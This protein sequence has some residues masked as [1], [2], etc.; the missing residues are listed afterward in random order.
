MEFCY[1]SYQF[2]SDK[3]RSTSKVQTRL[4]MGSLGRRLREDPVDG[5][6]LNNT[7]DIVINELNKILSHNPKVELQL[8]VSIV[9]ETGMTNF[10]NN[11]NN[12]CF[13]SH[14]ET[15][16]EET[17]FIY[18]E[19][20]LWNI[21]LRN[22]IIIKDNDIVID[23][24]ANIGLFSIFCGLLIPSIITIAIEPITISYEKLQNNLNYYNLN[25]L[26]L[27][28]SIGMTEYQNRPE[29]VII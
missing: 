27:K 3:L 22:G 25:S 16:P 18:K 11:C 24:G 7:I 10:D 4:K 12:Y 2:L 1:K 9:T 26:A 19:I 8:D 28:L 14:F 13:Y 17:V 21:Y 23:I 5:N 29:K 15:A 20:F 6:G